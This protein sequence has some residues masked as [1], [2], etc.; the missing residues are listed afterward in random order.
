M[1]LRVVIEESEDAT[2]KKRSEE[3]DKVI[4]AP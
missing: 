1:M 2:V 3:A 4:H